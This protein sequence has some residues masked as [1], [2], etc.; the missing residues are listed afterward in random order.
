MQQSVF[1]TSEKDA[2]ITNGTTCLNC[3]RVWAYISLPNMPQT[4]THK[5][6]QENVNPFEIE[7]QYRL[8]VKLEKR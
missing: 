4:K 2:S 6:I 1:N 5:Y 7:E 8:L 3:L